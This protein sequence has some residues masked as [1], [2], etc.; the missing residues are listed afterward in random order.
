MTLHPGKRRRQLSVASAT[1]VHESSGAR[2]G[3]GIVLLSGPPGQAE[4]IPWTELLRRTFG[5]ESVC[6]KCQAQLRLIAL[7][8]TED[9]AKKILTAMNF[10]PS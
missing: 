7:I 2:L 10:V 6:A 4:Y 9:V 1:I 5:F 8:K 3:A